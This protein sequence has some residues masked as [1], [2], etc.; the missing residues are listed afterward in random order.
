M[1]GIFVEAVALLTVGTAPDPEP[2][3]EHEE[4]L[5]FTVGE[6]GGH[7]SANRASLPV[8]FTGVAV[9][10]SVGVMIGPLATAAIGV[11]V[12]GLVYVAPSQEP[13]HDIG[14]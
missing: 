1:L 12:L 2:E 11:I 4:E 6:E 5:L 7:G 9:L 8:I 3:E 10:G 13:A 14:G